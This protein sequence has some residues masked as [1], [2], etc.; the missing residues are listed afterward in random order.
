MAEELSDKGRV[1]LDAA[2]AGFH[3]LPLQ[4][5]GK[6]PKIPKSQGG[7]GYKDATR[8]ETQIADWWSK[9]PN[10]NIG[11]RVG[12][13]PRQAMLI[14]IDVDNKGGK[15]GSEVLRAIEQKLVVELPKVITVSTP[16]GGFHYYVR[17]PGEFIDQLLHA[18]L[19][20]ALGLGEGVEIK[21]K[22]YVLLPGS[23]VSGDNVKVKALVNKGFYVFENGIE[24]QDIFTLLPD[25]PAEFIKACIKPE[26]DARD[27]ENVRK[28]R[29]ENDKGETLSEK[30]DITMA[31]VFTPPRD[32]ITTSDG[33]RIKH[34]VHGAANP[35]NV[36]I[37]M[38]TSQWYCHRHNH[39]GDA[40]EYYAMCG[41]IIGCGE[42][43]RG[44]AVNEAL[45]RLREE[46]I[47]SEVLADVQK[48]Q[49]ATVE[50]IAQHLAKHPKKLYAAF[51]ATI[52]DYHQADWKLKTVLW[53]GSFRVSLPSVVS[54]IHLD[55]SGPSRSG[56]TSVTVKFLD[57]IPAANK[58]ILFSTSAQ[59][60]WHM[61]VK[62]GKLDP[63]YYANKILVLLDTP[64]GALLE[65][66]KAACEEYE[67]TP[68]ERAIATD[69]A[70]QV[71]KFSI[72][73][74]RMVVLCS[75]QGVVDSN[76]QIASRC[77]QCPT[78]EQT[79]EHR[80]RRAILNSRNDAAGRNIKN[81]PRTSIIKR[82]RE[83]LDSAIRRAS[84]LEP[85]EGVQALMMGISLML[86]NDGF[87]ETQKR[88]FE[89]LCLCGAA[90]KIFERDAEGKTI[91]IQKEDV[92]EAWGIFNEFFEFASVNL[93]RQSRAVLNVIPLEGDGKPRFSDNSRYERALNHDS[94]VGVSEIVEKTKISGNR[95][96]EIVRSRAGGNE[97]VGPLH[98]NELIQS[99]K[100]AHDNHTVYWLTEKGVKAKRAKREIIRIEADNGTKF[101][102]PQI[103][104]TDGILLDTIPGYSELFRSYSGFQSRE[105]EGAT[106]PNLELKEENDIITISFRGNGN[107]KT[108]SL[109]Q[110]R[111]AVPKLPPEK[112]I[113]EGA[114]R[115]SWTQD[116]SKTSKTPDN[117]KKPDKPLEPQDSKAESAGNVRKRLDSQKA[118]LEQI[119]RQAILTWPFRDGNKVNRDYAVSVIAARVRQHQPNAGRELE[120]EINRLAVEDPEIQTFLA[121]RTGIEDTTRPN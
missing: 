99:T 36:S 83:I 71:M 46:G 13:G 70:G 41:G 82:A 113:L 37:K 19:G 27:W 107:G 49:K 44:N 31:K 18:D 26:P 29:P 95:V 92:L 102:E 81:D 51:S 119:I 2:R 52:D 50:E 25:L 104:T 39:G 42:R 90:E 15:K 111:D 5:T 7:N 94:L 21:A 64:E 97:R 80:T 12:N 23:H 109:F 121:E 108:K 65:V 40:L 69:K 117:G 17:Y 33:Y 55:M 77:I 73:G 98:D 110:E 106:W 114:P 56:K 9:Y 93:N 72:N 48:E 76:G 87:N 63:L 120:Y 11:V 74:P 34:P 66:L 4:A 103:P 14:A 100:Y 59:A 91:R 84:I 105:R 60:L 28:L 30:Y 61:T 118:D 3:V 101:Y 6:H 16:N 20:V 24:L 78:D 57:F 96:Y 68:M 62:D 116:S 75:V 47:I 67:D 54:L 38:G 86:V 1:A 53:R 89:A 45:K 85:S 43:L 22:G 8:D 35:H 58:E 10:A 115:E 32:A 112:K 88:Q 79:D